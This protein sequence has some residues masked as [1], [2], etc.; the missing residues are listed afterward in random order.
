MNVAVAETVYIHHKGGGC[1]IGRKRTVSEPAEKMNIS[2]GIDMSEMRRTSVD[3]RSSI[4][5]HCLLELDVATW[6]HI[7]KRTQ[8]E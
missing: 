1:V 5:Y 6:I 7:L 3:G 2:V 8:C 4:F